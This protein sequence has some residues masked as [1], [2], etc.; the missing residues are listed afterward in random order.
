MRLKS[1]AAPKTYWIERKK[2]NWV[3]KSMPGPHKATESVPL[4]VLI[5]DILKITKTARETKTLLRKGSVLVNGLVRRDLNYSCGLMDVVSLPKLKK[6]YRIAFDYKGRIKVDPIS[7][8][9]SDSKLVKVTR[10][11]IFKDGYQLVTN[12][13]R[14]IIMKLK[15]GSKINNNDSLLIKVPSQEIIKHIQLKKGCSILIKGGKHK[16]ETAKLVELKDS[17]A[18]LKT[19]KAEFNL[20]KEHV[21]VIGE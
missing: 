11:I 14:T 19:S 1:L 12:D 16:G 7:A 3:A 17:V 5:R 20:N 18:S 9:E 4:I 13:G 6:N 8:K 10:K 15:E 2:R 21:I